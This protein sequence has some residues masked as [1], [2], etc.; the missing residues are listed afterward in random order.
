MFSQVDRT[1]HTKNHD[2]CLALLLLCLLCP[3][4]Q[5]QTI[6]TEAQPDALAPLKVAID[7]TPFGYQDDKGVTRGITPDVIAAIANLMGREVEFIHMPFLRALHEL[8]TGGVDIVNG[9]NIPSTAIRLPPE[10]I[11][12][13]TPHTTL[14]LSLYSLADRGFE[15]HTRD[16]AKHYQIGAVRI[17]ATGHRSPWL[18][19]GNTHYFADSEN[20]TKA[21]LAKRVDLATLE[22]VSAA[23]IS[24]QLGIE[25]S[26][27]FDFGRVESFPLF[28]S[29]SPRI[30]NPLAF[31]QDYISAQIKLFASRQ[32]EALLKAHNMSSLLPF[33]NQDRSPSCLITPPE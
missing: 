12:A 16:E 2:R 10:T 29:A 22:P 25:L 24:K 11:T 4:L 21:L 18:D 33:V 27:V 31:C 19:Q 32:F 9:I 1:P 7:P 14:P 15:I 3:P 26:R 20:L 23:I 6:P 28:S 17:S 30:G 13:L 5:A 8:K